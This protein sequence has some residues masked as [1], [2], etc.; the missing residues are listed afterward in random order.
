MSAEAENYWQIANRTV[1]SSRLDAGS[2]Y[3]GIGDDGAAAGYWLS[4]PDN[5]LE[6]GK[7]YKLAIRVIT[8][9]NKA[10]LIKVLDMPAPARPA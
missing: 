3:P 9:S 7:T 8:N 1:T 4:I 2:S 6:Q 10:C 5:L